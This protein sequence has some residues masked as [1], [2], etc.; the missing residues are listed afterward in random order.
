MI[1]LKERALKPFVFTTTA[2]YIALTVLYFSPLEI[3]WK[4]CFPVAL[5]FIASLWTT[6]GAISIALLF[7]ALGDAAGA[8]GNILAQIGFFAL[9]HIC[10]I[11]FF[12]RRYRTKIE[13]GKRLSARAVAHLSVFSL[14]VL[15]LMAI[16]FICVVP[17]APAGT[18][19][20]GVAL[21]TIIISAMLFMA[22]LQ[23]SSLYT[24]GAALFVI[25]D[26]ILAWNLFVEPISHAGA[27]IMTTY[28]FAQWLIFIRAT[29]YKVPH[30]VK[31][32]RF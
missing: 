4:L 32:M 29:P 18:I 19:R 17:Q 12:I 23:R 3:G 21:Y 30:P 22:M 25:S 10:Y 14:C 9:G 31:L 13:P 24:L 20:I 5:L 15:A 2:A 26:L 27:M 7:S 16:S 1:A 8:C 11:S 6:P 28:Y